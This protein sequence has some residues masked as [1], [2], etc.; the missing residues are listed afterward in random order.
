[1]TEKMSSFVH[2]RKVFGETNL[3][4]KMK[5]GREPSFLKVLSDNSD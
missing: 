2:S 5:G 1:L 3:L 4:K